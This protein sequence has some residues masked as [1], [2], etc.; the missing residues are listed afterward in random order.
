MR[1]RSYGIALR[2][3]GRLITE[4]VIDPHY[5]K[6]HPDMTDAVI[7][8]LVRSLDQCEFSAEESDG[9]FDFYMLDRIPFA[10]KEYRLVWCMQK[11]RRYIGVINAFRR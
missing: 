3:N 7:L 8:G 2:V 10:G 1:R 9:E 6:N 5:E 4:V 11:E